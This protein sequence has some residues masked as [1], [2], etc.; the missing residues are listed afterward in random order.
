MVNRKGIHSVSGD[1]KSLKT[2][3]HWEERGK[4]EEKRYSEKP[5]T[6]GSALITKRKT[7]ANATS[8]LL[9][10][11]ITRTFAKTRI[12]LQI[13]RTDAEKESFNRRSG[14]MRN[15]LLGKR[16]LV[17]ALSGQKPGKRANILVVRGIAGA[18]QVQALK[19]VRN[20]AVWRR[21]G[22]TTLVSR[23]KRSAKG[24]LLGKNGKGHPLTHRLG[25]GGWGRHEGRRECPKGKRKKTRPG[26]RIWGVGTNAARHPCLEKSHNYNAKQKAKKKRTSPQKIPRLSSTCKPAH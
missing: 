17:T 2:L 14:R 18:S 20:R 5:L 4:D 25:N 22:F 23:R 26:K 10:S 24:T 19:K 13:L 3:L 6:V 1:Q 7:L 15:W 12:P 11:V 16:G 21:A 8:R 9:P